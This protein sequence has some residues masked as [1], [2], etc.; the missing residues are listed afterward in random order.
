MEPT[1]ARRHDVR[2][3]FSASQGVRSC[4]LNFDR[5]VDFF[6]LQDLVDDSSSVRRYLPF[7]DFTGATLPTS[8]TQY[9]E[10]L[11]RQVEF[12]EARNRRFTR[13][14]SLASA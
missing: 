7:D 12:A 9:G 6:L 1:A 10:F 3:G 13:A 5:Y 8:S 4:R 11:Q 14:L 2:A